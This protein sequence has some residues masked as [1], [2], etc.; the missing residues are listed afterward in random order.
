MSPRWIFCI[1]IDRRDTVGIARPMIFDEAIHP[2][3]GFH[4]TNL[5]LSSLDTCAYTVGTSCT[6]LSTYN[7]GQADLWSRRFSLNARIDDLGQYKP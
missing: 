4:G 5:V 1:I 6:W 7:G 3:S 2:G